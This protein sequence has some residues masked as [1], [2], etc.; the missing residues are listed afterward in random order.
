MNFHRNVVGAVTDSSRG[1][2]TENWSMQRGK[3]GVT[4]ISMKYFK[5]FSQFGQEYLRSPVLG[6]AF[7]CIGLELTGNDSGQTGP[8]WYQLGIQLMLELKMNGSI[9]YLSYMY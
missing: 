9:M 3:G 7:S 6:M 2:I 4:V 8:T 1:S 5:K